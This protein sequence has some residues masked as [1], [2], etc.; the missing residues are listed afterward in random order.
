ML[1]NPR[2]DKR[3]LQWSYRVKTFQ[4]DGSGISQVKLHEKSKIHRKNCPRDQRTL[5]YSNGLAQ[6]NP[7]NS[8]VTFS[9]EEQVIRAKIY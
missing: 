4:I 9:P 7:S 8:G 5:I 6:L 2:Y 1:K 3:N